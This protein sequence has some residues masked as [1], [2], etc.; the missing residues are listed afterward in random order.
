MGVIARWLANDGFILA[1]YPQPEHIPLFHR[2]AENVRPLGP[3]RDLPGAV[4]SLWAEKHPYYE[5]GG[6]NVLELKL[7]QGHFSSSTAGIRASIISEYN[8]WAHRLLEELF[9]TAQKEK[10]PVVYDLAAPRT[11]PD[12]RKKAWRERHTK[13]FTEMAK[14][15]GLQVSTDGDKLVARQKGP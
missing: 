2:A 10:L 9:D 13:L 1:Y 4:G 6:P 14:R 8:R 11:V 12:E 3:S 5:G 7:L 15:K